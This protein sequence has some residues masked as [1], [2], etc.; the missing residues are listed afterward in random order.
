MQKISNLPKI[1][2][3]E[4]KILDQILYFSRNW[5]LKNSIIQILFRWLNKYENI[6]EHSSK[7]SIIKLKSFKEPI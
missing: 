6:N 3:K 2:E 7:S 5:G 1:I 4:K